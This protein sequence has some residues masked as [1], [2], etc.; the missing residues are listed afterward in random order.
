M[1]DKKIHSA[2]RNR[3]NPD[4]SSLRTMQLRM[5]DML[6]FIDQICTENHI[7]YWLSSGTCLGAIRHG[8]FIPWDDDVDIEMLEPDYRRLRKILRKLPA[9]SKYAWQDHSTDKGYL[10]SYGKLRDKQSVISEQTKWSKHYK[11]SGIFIDVFHLR[12]SWSRQ[13]ERVA[14]AYQAKILYNLSGAANRLVFNALVRPLSFL[15]QYAVCPI[16]NGLESIG[17][18]E[19]LR[20]SAGTGF[21]FPR[22]RTDVKNVIRVPF[23]DTQLPVPASYDA[24]LTKIYGDYMA[25]PNLDNIQV[26][27]LSFRLI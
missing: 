4:G 3:F 21:L 14:N 18:S 16:I 24:Y 19:R 12:P 11:Y 23:E 20:H 10:S 5:L 6:K 25:L 17:Q 1:I 27:A 7:T 22:Y 2:L 26:H 8:G 15:Y 13:L 9:D